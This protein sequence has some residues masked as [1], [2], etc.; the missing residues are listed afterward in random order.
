MIKIKFAY[1]P[2]CTL[3]TKARE[4]NESV[5]AV[6]SV[7]GIELEELPSWTCCGAVIPLV[8]DNVMN[9]I[10]PIRNII[11]AKKHGHDMVALCSFCY[12]VLK[13]A[14][15][16]VKED[17]EKLQKIND[18]IE[19][20]KKYDG[21]VKV[22]HL[23]ELLKDKIGFENLGKMVKKN[24]SGLR[25]APYYGCMLLRPAEIGIDDPEE[26]RILENFL[27]AL[28]C[29]VV[30]FPFKTECCGSYLTVSSP[31]TAMECSYNILNSAVKNKADIIVT[32]CP[33]CHFNLDEKQE[34]MV[35]KYSDFKKIS[36]TYFTRPLEIALGM[37]I[38]DRSERDFIEILKGK[39]LLE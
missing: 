19:E 13:R 2:G 39:N 23:L 24:L 36:V 4:F 34:E 11:Y 29:E 35:K 37:D 27:E 12:N 10:A 6:S 21:N 1:Y 25:V 31:D 9:L 33:L 16:A 26:P 22:F 14:N 20:E 15:N 30:D 18:F 38:T 32:S 17:P 28:G 8:T 5:K 7:L 3:R